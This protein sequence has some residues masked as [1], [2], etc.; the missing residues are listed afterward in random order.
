MTVGIYLRVST[1]EQ[2]FEGYSLA[3]QRERL[4][5]FCVAQGWESYKFYV[6]EGK[7]GKTTEKRPALDKLMKDIEKGRIQI[8][9]VY[10]LDRLTRSVRDLHQILHFLEDHKC[11]FRSATEIYDT[12]TAMGRMFITIV[13]AIAEW[14]SANLGERVKMGQIEKARQGKFSAPSPYGFYKDEDHKLHIHSEDIQAVHLMIGKIE[15][16]MSFRQLSKFMETTKFRPRRGYKWHIRSMMD[17]LANPVLYGATR[18]RDEIIEGTHEG[19]MSKAEFEHLQRL[20]TSRQNHKKRHID[21]PVIYQ[22]VLVCPDCGGRLAYER[23]NWKVKSGERRVL[24]SYRCQACALNG[25]TPPFRTSEKIINELLI[26]YF[27]GFELQPSDPETENKL[28]ELQREI[29]KVERQR[30]RYQR[31][32]GAE[33]MTDEE[34]KNHMNDTKQ[35]LESLQLELADVEDT[36]QDKEEIAQINELAK[37]FTRSFI[38][39]NQEEKRAFVQTFISAIEIEVIERCKGKAHRNQVIDIK[40]V[41]FV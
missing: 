30:D 24:N 6:E 25:R 21:F 10:R 7:S 34:F 36:V 35:R 41:H 38:L 8:L 19:I 4:I 3:A 12:S 9:L 17:I 31:A 2:A 27:D 23:T 5:A 26:A 20:I 33:L 32:W 15:E 22:T 29:V 16:G 40:M 1:E 14:E 39:L 37:N 18:W 13:A 28:E 11:T